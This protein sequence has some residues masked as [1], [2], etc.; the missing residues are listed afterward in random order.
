MIVRNKLYPFILMIYYE[1]TVDFFG[2]RGE[3][4]TQIGVAI[5]YY[6]SKLFGIVKA[7]EIVRNKLSPS[8]YELK[9]V[10]VYGKYGER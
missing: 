10:S 1:A 9:K 7:L 3:G 5:S 6:D 4:F 8:V 2:D